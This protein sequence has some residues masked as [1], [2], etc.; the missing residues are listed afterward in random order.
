MDWLLLMLSTLEN[1]LTVSLKHVCLFIFF[2]LCS[3]YPPCWYCPWG[4]L[5]QI[6]H[7]GNCNNHLYGNSLKMLCCIR[8]KQRR[9]QQAGAGGGGGEWD[10]LGAFLFIFSGFPAISCSSVFQVHHSHLLKSPQITSNM[11]LSECYFSCQ[12]RSLKEKKIELCCQK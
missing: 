2:S 6:F 5:S 11:E 4:F 9:G 8:R 10:R 3:A 1:L 7:N 12:S